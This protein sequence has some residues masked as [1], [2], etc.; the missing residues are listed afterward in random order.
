MDYTTVSLFI[1]GTELTRGIIADKHG[2]LMANEL[3]RLGYHINRMVIVPDDGTLG[4]VLRQ[5]LQESDIVILTG[6]LG[7]TS[8]DLTRS[9]VASIA[10]VPL[11]MDEQSYQDLRE[12]IGDRINGSNI[13]QVYFPQGFTPIVNPKGTA[14]GFKGI[15]EVDKAGVKANILCYAMPGPPVEMH[16]MFYHRVLPELANLSGHADNERDEFS[17]FLIPESKLEEACAQAAVDDLQWGTR[18]QE[19]R[20]SLYISGGD[21]VLRL[22]MRDRIEAIVGLGLVEIGDIEAVDILSGYLSDHHLSIAC[23]ESCTGGLVSKLLTDKGGSSAWFWGTVV[24]YANEAKTGLLGVDSA[25]IEQEGAVSGRCVEAMADGMLS[26]SHADTAL[27]ISG[28]AGP[29]GG[30][31]EKPV[32]LV[33]FGFAAKNRPTTSVAVKISSFGRASVRRRAAVAA[34]LLAFSYLNGIDLL[35]RVKTW[36]YI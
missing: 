23:A 21:H 16:E 28:I 12:R 2:Q 29:D 33:W 20:I 30:T 34:F 1:I 5:C 8:D 7:P 15:L 27:A 19:H 25:I 26:R 17:T 35:D 3:T 13:R 31:P 10:K 6:G 18:V 11:V 22:A 24:S 14:P 4:E 9:L 36:Q 32:G